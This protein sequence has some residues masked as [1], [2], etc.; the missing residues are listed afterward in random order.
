MQPGQRGASDVNDNPFATE[1]E[2]KA[3]LPYIEY[4][5]WRAWATGNPIKRTWR[6]H[7][8][9]PIPGVLDAAEDEG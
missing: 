5:I 8:V 4:R 2:A 3:A 6:K 9:K 1:A 7:A